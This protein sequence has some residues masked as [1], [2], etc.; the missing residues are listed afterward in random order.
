M[1]KETD[2]LHQVTLDPETRKL[3]RDAGRSSF[4]G[5]TLY[6]PETETFMPVVRTPD[7]EWALAGKSIARDWLAVGNGLR[8]AMGM[9][10]IDP[11]VLEQEQG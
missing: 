9:K 10:E 7:E 4:E 3:Y 1:T 8:R 2:L 11:K 5:I 6:P